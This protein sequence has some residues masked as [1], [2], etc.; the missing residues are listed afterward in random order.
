M[1]QVDLACWCPGR[2]GL[3]DKV[4]VYSSSSPAP[5]SVSRIC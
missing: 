3:R 4:V 2:R 5:N 1:L